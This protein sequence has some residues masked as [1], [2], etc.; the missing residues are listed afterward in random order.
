MMNKNT[1]VIYSEWKHLLASAS[2]S[3][4]ARFLEALLD[5]HENTNQKF[6]DPM[7]QGVWNFISSQINKDIEK[8]E[9]MLEKRRNA[10]R[11]GGQ[12]KLSKAKQ[13]L[14]KLSKAKHNDNVNENDNDN[15]NK[16]RIYTV[17]FSFLVQDTIPRIFQNQPYIFFLYL[18]YHYHSH[19]HYHYA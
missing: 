12:A 18:H 1:I 14:A 16:E 2:D 19:L 17:F 4:K 10:G 6:D 3:S 15:V 5:Y 11:K 13:S 8:Y 9:E 7:I